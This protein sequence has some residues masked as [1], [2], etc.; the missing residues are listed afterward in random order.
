MLGKTYG[1]TFQTAMNTE[2]MVLYMYYDWA[3]W[4]QQYDIYLRAATMGM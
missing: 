1:W 2:L 3:I 4:D